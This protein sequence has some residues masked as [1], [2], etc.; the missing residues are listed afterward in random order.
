M[1]AGMRQISLASVAAVVLVALSASTVHATGRAILVNNNPG[2]VTVHGM[3]GITNTANTAAE[4]TNN[5]GNVDLGTLNVTNTTSNQ[6]GLVAT[7]NTGSITTDAGTINCG[8]ATTVNIDGPAGTTPLNM[9]LASV[10]S[11]GGANVGINIQDTSGSF[12][13]TGNGALGPDITAN[14]G[15]GGVIANKSGNGINLTN[16]TN[17]S[18]K[19]MN[20]GAA[21]G[22]GNIANNGV[23]ANNV[24]GLTI[25]RTNFRNCANQTNPNEAALFVTN[26]TGD[27]L[28][29]NTL[30]ERSF[31]DHFRMENDNNA[32]AS[33]TFRDCLI[34]DNNDSGLGSDGILYQGDNGSSALIT[35][36]SSVFEDN[37]GDHIQVALNGS[38][39]ANVTIG[40][41]AMADG[42]TMRVNAGENVLGSGIT[43]S[44]GQGAGGTNF[45]GTLTY[46]IRHNNIQGAQAAAINVNM[47]TSSTA[48]QR[49]TGT[50]ANNTV[51]TSGV[52]GSGGFGIGVTANG[53]GT[54]NAD[55]V[56]NSVLSWDGGNAL[57]LTARDGSNRLNATVRG[58][59]LLEPNP[60]TGNTEAAAEVAS[61]AIGTDTCVICLNITDAG[62]SNNGNNSFDVPTDPQFGDMFFGTLGT[63]SIQIA[64]YAGA[65]N[66]Q[67]AIQSFVQGGNN[68][69]PTVNLFQ[70]GGPVGSGPANGCP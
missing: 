56:D 13:V 1:K 15:S 19:Y 26:P 55:V 14:N 6:P 50:I 11:S 47:S 30:M 67:A 42:N 25:T 38:A 27:Y 32:L 58:N 18:L 17:V 44:S 52:P 16:A 7:G 3:S 43:F 33:L 20:I 70:F 39:S 64:G 57:T 48:G 8:S 10:S 63:G 46:L 60:V 12:T 65:D 68:G 28:V 53:S 2:S 37:D 49:Y 41:D 29:A 23:R 34:R 21:G 35:I 54:L 69:T 66:N 36:E 31:D 22:L 5:A 62:G 51:G 24:S 45:S 59:T 40:G 61:G 4:L 9:S